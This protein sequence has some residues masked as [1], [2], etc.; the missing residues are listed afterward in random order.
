MTF[1]DATSG[2]TSGTFTDSNGTTITWT[3]DRA[4]AITQINFGGI[5]RVGLNSLTDQLTTPKQTVLEAV[6]SG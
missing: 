3:S 6:R 1:T 4:T 2:G 5:S